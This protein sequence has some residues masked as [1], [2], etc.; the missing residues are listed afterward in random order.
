LAGCAI[1]AAIQD[2]WPAPRIRVA[3]R[4]LREGLLLGMMGADQRRARRK[5]NARQN[6]EVSP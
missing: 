5:A 1:L 6:K 2:V 3:D 4:G